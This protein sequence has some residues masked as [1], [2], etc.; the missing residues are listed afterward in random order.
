MKSILTCCLY[1]ICLFSLSSCEKWSDNTV[2]KTFFKG[3]Q[4]NGLSLRLH[5]NTIINHSDQTSITVEINETLKDKLVVTK[6][7]NNIVT[8]SINNFVM[9]STGIFTY[10]VTANLNKINL[11]ESYNGADIIVNGRFTGE[12]TKIKL[13]SGATLKG[14]NLSLTGIYNVDLWGGSQIEDTISCPN[15]VTQIQIQSS[16]KSHILNCDNAS[17]NL[18]GKSKINLTGVEDPDNQFN[19][20]TINAI[21][22]SSIDAYTIKFNKTIADLS[23]STAKVSVHGE[24]SG[25]LQF[26]STLYYKGDPKIDQIIISPDSKL[27]KE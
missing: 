8:I 18:A 11:I 1:L 15:I 14:L 20:I 25:N 26:K 3:E 27:I 9:P 12:N 21:D 22:D 2:K 5:P 16:I 17:Y 13:H 23:K 4:I 7:E 24:L 19:S 6:N 10:N